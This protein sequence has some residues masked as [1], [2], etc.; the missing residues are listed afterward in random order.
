MTA[1]SRLPTRPSRLHIAAAALACLAALIPTWALASKSGF[2]Y[3]GIAHVSWWYNEYNNYDQL[4]GAATDS[5][6]ALAATGANWAALLVTQYQDT[7]TSTLIAP[8]A[9][10]NK[11]P[12]DD[13]LR[14]AIKEFHDEGLKVM[15][16]PHVDAW[17]GQWRGEFVPADVDAW[18]ASYT[19]FI[20]HYAQLA[21]EQG[22]EG[23]VMGTEFV[24]LSGSANRDRWIAVIKAIRNVYGGVLA[25]AA[26]ATYPADEFTSVS[27]WDQVDLIGLDAYFHLTDSTTATLDQLVS[28]W[29]SNSYGENAVAAVQN[30]ASAQQKPVIFTELGYKSVDGANIEPWNYSRSGAYDPE[31]QRD[32]YEAAFE[33]WSQ[34]TSIVKGIFWW[35]WPVPAP[36]ANDLDYN[37][38]GKL[39]ETVL[40]T[41]QGGAVTPGFSLAANPASL[42]INLGASGTST[43]TV[44]P[45]GGFAD[46]VA[47]SASGLPD[48]VTAT[49][50]P[51]STTGTST[52]TLAASS[53]AATGPASVTITGAGGGV[54]RTAAISLTVNG[55]AD[56]SSACKVAYQLNSQWSTGFTVG[57]VITNTGARAIDGWTLKWSFSS[58]QT[59]S[60]GWCG[61]FSQSG[62]QVAVTNLDWNKAIA[63]GGSVS[64]GFVGG[65]S[66]DSNPIPSTF[67]LNGVTCS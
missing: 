21:Q 57:V 36:G 41:W 8:R 24:K 59:V 61:T 14:F 42:T 5:R 48:G 29:T 35:A 47:L 66:S 63:P 65:L 30:L 25:Y 13:S 60:Q 40:A 33:V 2:D 19:Q 55:G 58:G 10:E 50:A 56:T 18:F 49:F 4:T 44:T 45:S 37:P 46:S 20:V 22:V 64:M 23:L 38:R 31:E 15:L 27:F 32:C 39:A 53:T 7:A 6:T 11:T 54:T 67:T 1:R 51:A 62:S 43:V 16:K 28:A 3:G 52:L 26:N 12:T 34:Q 9:A 17:N